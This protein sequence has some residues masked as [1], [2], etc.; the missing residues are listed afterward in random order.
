VNRIV[1]IAAREA[2]EIVR[3]PA[4]MA[5]IAS[6]FTAIA[7]LL[8]VALV[9]LQLVATVGEAD[10]ALRAWLQ[11]LGLGS[12]DVSDLYGLVV[13]AGA[14]LLVTQYLGICGVL[15]GH[16]LLHDRLCGTLPFLLLAPVGRAELLAGKVAGALVAPTALYLVTQILVMGGAAALPLGGASAGVLPPSPTWVVAALI[17]GPVW[18]AAIAVVCAIVSALARDVRAAQQGVWLIMLFA[19]LGAGYL[20]A[21]RLA[22]GVLVQLLV[23]AGGAGLAAAALA[24]GGRILSRDLGR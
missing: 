14:F 9:L 2:R 5:S 20:L 16:T 3:Q 6:L 11:A 22:D 4:T 19:T 8:V 7:M 17:G 1:T 10:E 18:A 13:G 15:A 12:A 23:A 21:G 24:V